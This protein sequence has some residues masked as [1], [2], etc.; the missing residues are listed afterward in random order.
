MTIHKP[1][2]AVIGV[3]HRGPSTYYVKRS[4]EMANYP[5]VWSLMSIQFQTYQLPDPLDLGAAGR[6]LQEM[7]D[8]RLGGVSIAPVRYLTSGS[9]DVNPMGV[10]VTLHLYE[11]ELAREPIL[12]AR[13]YTDAAWLTPDEYE[14]RCAEQVCGLCLR[15]W[16]DY[17]WMAQI[18]D[19]PFIPRTY[20]PA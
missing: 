12:N 10:D 1:I 4:E 15:L 9:S 7:S 2:N 13:Y 11:M 20:Q 19:R 18:T 16:A 8:E 3:R 14:H 5:S 6:L 17:A